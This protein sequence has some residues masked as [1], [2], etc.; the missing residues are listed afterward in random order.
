MTKDSL[1]ALVQSYHSHMQD[2]IKK[3]H[4]DQSDINYGE[5]M[6]ARMHMSTSVLTLCHSDF[7]VVTA[8]NFNRCQLLHK[9]MLHS[10]YFISK[11]TD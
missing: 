6:T 7:D 11:L 2:V 3:L 8:A 9:W 10:Q 4:Q 5:T 1:T